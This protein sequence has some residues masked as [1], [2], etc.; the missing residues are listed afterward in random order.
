MTATNT[1]AACW[2][3]GRPRIVHGKPDLRLNWRDDVR[4]HECE[5]CTQELSK[6]PILRATPSPESQR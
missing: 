6:R 4:G 3:C 1:N 5:D 2:L